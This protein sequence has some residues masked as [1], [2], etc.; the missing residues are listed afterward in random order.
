MSFH[1][2]RIPWSLRFVAVGTLLVVVSRPGICGPTS[3]L[4]TPLLLVGLA[5]LGTGALLALTWALA[6]AVRWLG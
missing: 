2:S 1:P 6:R 3:R 4:G 5:C